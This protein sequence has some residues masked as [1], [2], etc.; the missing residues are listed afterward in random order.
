[1]CSQIYK[2]KCSVAINKFKSGIDDRVRSESRWA[3]G[4]T[5]KV[6][7]D[8]PNYRCSPRMIREKSG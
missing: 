3:P 2:A 5:W 4:T 7:F 1:M 8:I 6:W